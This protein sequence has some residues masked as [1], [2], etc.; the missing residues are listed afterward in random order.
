ML[1]LRG[2]PKIARHHGPAVV[3]DLVVVGPQCDHG[4]DREG[5]ARLHDRV[6]ARIVVV[7][8]DQAAV[9]RR[10]DS[11][12]G[13][14]A[15]DAVP[16]SLG[17]ALDHPADDVD[18]ASGRDGLDGSHGRLVGAL[19]EEARF[20]AHLTDEEGGVGVAVHATDEGR[21]VD[22]ADVAIDQDCRVGD[23]VADDLIERGAQGLGESAVAQSG[24]VGA[25][26]EEEFMPDPV[27]IVR[28]HPGGDRPPH[29]RQGLSGDPTRHPHALD[30][31]GVLDLRADESLRGWPV[32]VLRPGNFGR[33]TAAG[34]L[35]P[36]HERVPRDGHAGSLGVRR[37]G[38]PR[39]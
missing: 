31:L 28:G 21:D 6:V 1:E 38:R 12:T 13:E 10:P 18:G 9:E 2:E 36:G 27:E 22:V 5:H 24:G 34:R 29:L 4:F 16:E 32:D 7:G 11:V 20:L 17:V 23:P 8:D 3:P 19:D 30:G 14:V 15:D 39:R 26:V 25:V 37:R 35:D 33:D